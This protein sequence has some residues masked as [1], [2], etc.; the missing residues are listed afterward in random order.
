MSASIARPELRAVVDTNLFISGLIARND[1]SPARIVDAVVA[2]RF[3]LVTSAD[4]DGEILEVLARPRLTRD[5]ATDPA[6]REPVLD[7]IATAE[8]VI[9]AGTIPS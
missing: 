7:R 1:A 3:T 4:L 6:L 2:Q 5:Y 9:H 8:H